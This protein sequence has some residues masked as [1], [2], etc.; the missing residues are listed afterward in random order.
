MTEINA[1]KSPLEWHD[2]PDLTQP[3]LVTGFH[4]WS[5]AGSVS[6]DT[7]TFLIDTLRP[8]VF[9]TLDEESFVNYTLDRPIAQIEDGVIHEMEPMACCFASWANS[10]AGHDL[11]LFL[12]REPHFSWQSYSRIVLDLIDKLGVIRLYT[13]GGVQDTVSHTSPPLISV[14]GSSP[15]VVTETL[16]LGA[17]LRA[18]EYY[19]PVSIHSCLVRTCSE[20]GI[21]AVSLWGHVPAYLQKSPRVVTKLVALLN[22]VVGMHCPV[23]GL[24]QKTQEL[25]K[26]INEALLRDPS[27]KKFVDS[28][29]QEKKSETQAKK[30]DKIIR[31]DDFVRRDSRNDP[32]PSS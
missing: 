14:V 29:E 10:D 24:K 22:R 8:R 32:E 28:I 23:H 13:V 15:S 18:A 20:A 12:G 19:G 16:Q 4:G 21:E 9:A 26:K 1:P 7:L 2:V 17:G 25:D 31:L 3:L 30:D 11:V 27:L 5:D 6:S